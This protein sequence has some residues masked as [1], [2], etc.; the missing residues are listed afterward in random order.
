L[1]DSAPL[2][3]AFGLLI[4]GLKGLISR[5]LLRSRQRLVRWWDSHWPLATDPLAKFPLHFQA[6]IHSNNGATALALSL[7]DQA[8]N[9]M[10]LARANHPPGETPGAPWLELNL[11][12]NVYVNAGCYGQALSCMFPW[13]TQLDAPE[14]QDGVIDTELG[15]ILINQAEALHNLGRDCEALAYL[16]RVEK[17]IDSEFAQAGLAALRAWILVH[18]GDLIAAK[19]YIDAAD[20]AVL[21]DSY[22]PE[23]AFTR[24]ALLRDQGEFVLAFSVLELGMSHVKRASSLRNGLVMKASIYLASGDFASAQR[25]FE[26]AFAMAYTGQAAYGILR[27]ADMQRRTAGI[28]LNAHAGANSISVDS[29]PEDLRA[30]WQALDPE[31]RLS[32]RVF[33]V[34]SRLNTL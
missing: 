32:M 34:A 17:G 6:F 27:V 9:T 5:I 7:A 10:T 13:Q 21:A 28:A 31:S 20:C 11:L 26:Q 15:I 19:H 8:L 3:L 4:F 2:V 23:I 14:M 12:I 25:L 24:A 16:D 30:Q 18:R 1:T 22:A 29:L 33:P